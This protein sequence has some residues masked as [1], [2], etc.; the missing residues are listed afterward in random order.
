[1]LTWHTGNS[2]YTNSIVDTSA[3]TGHCDARGLDG[4]QAEDESLVL[5]DELDSIDVENTDGQGTDI[6]DDLVGASFNLVEVPGVGEIRPVVKVDLRPSRRGAEVGVVVS[7][8]V[9][10]QLP[11]DKL[12]L[13]KQGNG[14]LGSAA[15]VVDAEGRLVV[16]GGD[17]ED[18]VIR[19]N[20]LEIAGS[21]IG[22]DGHFLD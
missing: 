7:L 14:P 21:R 2:I 19:R 15:T 9:I 5:R 17:V 4:A 16:I 10:V 8:E 13:G 18:A 12:A 11:V 6:V 22:R 20:D 3:H 1:M